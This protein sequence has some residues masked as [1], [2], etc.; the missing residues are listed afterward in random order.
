MVKMTCSNHRVM[1]MYRKNEY[2]FGVLGAI[3][4]SSTD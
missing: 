3:F 1:W 4:F 2:S